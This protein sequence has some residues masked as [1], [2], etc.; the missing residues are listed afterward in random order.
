MID[1]L[2]TLAQI[3]ASGSFS[4]A[5]RELGLSPSSVSRQMDRL[6]A[7]F[8]V[9]LMF[10]STHHVTLT[11]A[12]QQVLRKAQPVFE[13]LDE[14]GD[15]ARQ[16]HAEPRGLLRVSAFET[17]G[18][19]RIAP[20]LPEFLRRYPQVQLC[21]ELDNRRVD[22][23]R[24]NYDLCVR[25][26]VPQD[27]SL[28]AR[29]L[30]P[31]DFVLVASPAYLAAHGMPERPQDLA[32]HNCLVLDRRRQQSWW[33]LQRNGETQRVAVSGNLLAPGGEVLAQGARAGLGITML[34]RWMVSDDLAGGALQQVLPDWQATIHEESAGGIYL[35]Y[36][37]E[38][39]QRPALR[40]LIDFLVEHLAH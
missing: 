39:Y 3:A 4:A 40:A 1:E 20:L 5:G 18:R 29:R 15:M 37:D 11:E 8:G 19:M 32:G 14:L 35:L 36:K 34:G 2:R 7:R 26:G 25:S 30:Q 27:S 23:L 31:M 10:R 21:L 28:R 6:E 33:H 12:G 22:P 17:Y 38:R 16:Q 9:Q 13:H 24:E